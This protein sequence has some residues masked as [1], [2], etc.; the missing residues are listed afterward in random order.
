MLFLMDFAQLQSEI[1]NT[2]FTE[3]VKEDGR[4]GGNQKVLSHSSGETLLK[5]I[6]FIPKC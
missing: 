3:L 4:K 6:L 5:T 2:R 1:K